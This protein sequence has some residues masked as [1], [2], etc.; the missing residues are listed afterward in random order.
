[1]VMGSIPIGGFPVG[2]HQPFF[3]F[4]EGWGG[5]GGARV[6]AGETLEFGA[7]R[8]QAHLGFLWLKTLLG[9]EGMRNRRSERA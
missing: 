3:G 6:R 5:G 4:G 9:G 1:M 8:R 7:A 2:E